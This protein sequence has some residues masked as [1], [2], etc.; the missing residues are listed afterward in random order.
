MSLRDIKAGASPE[1]SFDASRWSSTIDDMF[2]D[3]SYGTTSIS[4]PFRQPGFCPYDTV[5]DFDHQTGAHNSISPLLHF[6]SSPFLLFSTSQKGLSLRDKESV[7]YSVLPWLCPNGTLRQALRQNF[8]SMLRD[9]VLPWMICYGV[10]PKGQYRISP[11]RSELL[12]PF[13]PFPSSPLP[14]FPSSPFLSLSLSLPLSISLNQDPKRL[15][16]SS[17]L[18]RVLDSL[19]YYSPVLDLYQL[20]SNFETQT[21]TWWRNFYY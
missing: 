13:L 18:L 6:P 1:F 16:S 5:A 2:W 20:L 7:S 8:I 9:G 4:G 15:F 11:T 12:T 3:C 10:V 14:L 19:P 17:P 21:K